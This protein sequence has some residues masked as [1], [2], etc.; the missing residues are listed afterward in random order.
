MVNSDGRC[1]FETVRMC[2]TW[3]K[4][5]L[6]HSNIGTKYICYEKFSAT[7]IFHKNAYNTHNFDCAHKISYRLILTLSDIGL[8]IVH[9]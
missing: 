3:N 9:N 1:N 2:L 4:L 6:L 8:C 5:G 7:L